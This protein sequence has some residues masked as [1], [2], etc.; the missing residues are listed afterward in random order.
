M[1]TWIPS[2]HSCLRMTLSPLVERTLARIPEFWSF[3]CHYLSEFAV[4]HLEN[5]SIKK[6]GVYRSLPVLTVYDSVFALNGLMLKMFLRLPD[7]QL[8]N[9]VVS[10]R[11]A[12]HWVGSE[13]GDGHKAVKQ[14]YHLGLARTLFT[15]TKFSSKTMTQKKKHQFAQEW[16]L[17]WREEKRGKERRGEATP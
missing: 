16:E 11:V 9:C 13:G 4:L 15:N 1:E 7:F 12:W 17:G 3:H 8:D 10:W 2:N 6:D 5:G 14:K